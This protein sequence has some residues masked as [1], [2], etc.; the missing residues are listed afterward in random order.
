MNMK[1][2]SKLQK[3]NDSSS[4]WEYLINQVLNYIDGREENWG[5]LMSD[6]EYN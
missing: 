3:K 5:S 6:I 4:S 2:M 1:I